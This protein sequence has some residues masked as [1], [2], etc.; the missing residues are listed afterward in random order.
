MPE[1][2]AEGSLSLDDG[3]LVVLS[4]D[5]DGCA[6]LVNMHTVELS[7]KGYKLTPEQ[8]VYRAYMTLHNAARSVLIDKIIDCTKG[9]ADVEVFCGSNRQ[10]RFLDHDVLHSKTGAPG[11]ALDDLSAFAA[12]H[13]FTFNPFLLIDAVRVEA[14]GTNFKKEERSVS[15]SAGGSSRTRAIM[16]EWDPGKIKIITEQLNLI[17]Q[18]HP[19]KKIDYYFMDDDSDNIIFP[20]LQQYFTLNP[21]DIPKGI[22]ILFIKFDWQEATLNTSTVTNIMNETYDIEKL[23]S[24]IRETMTDMEPIT[25][26]SLPIQKLGQHSSKAGFFH[27]EAADADAESDTPPPTCSKK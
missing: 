3:E 23:K 1:T 16:P 15:H 21:N 14:P 2:N 18:Q 24:L 19:G 12:E 11:L 17:S 6:S 4:L 13:H 9:A 5:Y 10:S 20:G 8:P 25:A 7:L 27:G 22:R 26:P